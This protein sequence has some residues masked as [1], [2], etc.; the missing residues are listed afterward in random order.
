MSTP[1]IRALLSSPAP[2][3]DITVQGWVR[4]RRDSKVCTFIELNDGSCLRGIQ[5][6]ADAALPCA[7]LYPHILTGASVRVKGDLVQSPGAKQAF[8]V[9]AKDIEVL[10]EADGTYPLQKKGHTPEFLRTISHLRPRT[11][12]LGSVFRVRS[13][14]AFAIHQFFQER[15]FFYIHTPIITASDCEGAGEMFRVTTIPQGSAAKPETD[16]F[17]KPAFLTVSGQLQGE[18]FACALSRIYTFGPTFRAEN[19]NTA[20]HAAEFWMIEPEMAFHDLDADM[21]LAEENVKYL[22]RA[23]FETCGEELEFFNKFVDKD[24]IARLQHTLDKPF[25][26]VSYTDAVDILLKS[27]RTFEYPVEWGQNLQSEHERFLAEEHFKSPVTVFNYPK[28]LKPFYMRQNDDGKTV[29]AMDVLVPGIGEIIGG[30]QREERLD[31]LEAA[32]Q[33]QGLDMESYRWYSDLRRF[34]TVPHAGYGMGFER[35][36]MFATGVG[37]IRDVIP[38]ARTPGHAEF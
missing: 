10:G 9:L 22:L 23:L 24:L 5:V 11:N 25:Q 8:E 30:S 26:R 14:M 16:F 2:L 7:S 32:M 37:N 29:A 1:N 17:G 15:D 31:R 36:L 34:G 12:L 33:A 35:F 27:G 20:R 28:T 38:F 21:G 3:S 13:R 18:T 19:S 6:V 4:T